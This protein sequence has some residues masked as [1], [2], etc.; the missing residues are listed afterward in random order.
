[1]G[2]A[3]GDGGFLGRWLEYAS[4]SHG[5]NVALKS[6]EPQRLS[7]FHPR[8]CGI[9]GNSQRHPGDGVALEEQTTEPRDGPEQNLTYNLTLAIT[10]PAKQ[11]WD[12]PL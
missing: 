11:S 9:D 8:S 6:R 2:M 3:A 12:P 10:P 5:G 7:G 1:V 4:N